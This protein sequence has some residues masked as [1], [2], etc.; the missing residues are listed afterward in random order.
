MSQSESTSQEGQLNTF[1]VDEPTKPWITNQRDSNMQMNGLRLSSWL[2]EGALMS[3][4]VVISTPNDCVSS[5]TNKTKQN[6]N[7]TG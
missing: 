6:K 3:Q 2:A 7:P 5:Q 1:V 4:Y